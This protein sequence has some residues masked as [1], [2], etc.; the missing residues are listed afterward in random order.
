[1]IKK[2]ITIAALV[3]SI[4]LFWGCTGD[5]GQNVNNAVVKDKSFSVSVSLPAAEKDSISRAEVVVSGDDMDTLYGNLTIK[6]SSV[7]GTV[8]NIPLG[9]SRHIEIEVFDKNNMII[10][11]GDAYADIVS[12]KTINVTITMKCRR[13]S[14][15]VIGVINE[16]TDKPFF[17]ADTATVFLADFNDNLKDFITGDSGTLSAA[18][19]APGLL[20][21][22]FNSTIRLR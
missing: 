9:L 5:N 1:M 10:Y 19:F 16:N 3:V 2:T 6:N 22:E 18:R 13:G 12:D 15:N 21:K 8:G 20:G 7:S 14:I 4:A 17:A 11:Y